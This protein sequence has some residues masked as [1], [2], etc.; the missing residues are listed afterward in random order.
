MPP[1]F[2]LEPL[3]ARVVDRDRGAFSE[4]YDRSSP[5]VLG[6]LRRMLN[7]PDQAEEVAQ[8]VYVQVWQSAAAFDPNR[9]S[10]WSWLAMMA[11]SRAVD[12]IRADGSYRGTLD[13]ILAAPATAPAGNSGD[14]PDRAAVRNERGEM[15]RRAMERLPGEQRDALMMAFFGGYSHREIAERTAIPLGTVKTRI[16]TAMMNLKDILTPTMD[17]GAAE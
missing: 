10:G 11:R 5:Y 7:S 2:D 17:G 6:L 9:G 8:E 14:A 1:P 16:R 4:L 15:V 3:L 13:R 12:R